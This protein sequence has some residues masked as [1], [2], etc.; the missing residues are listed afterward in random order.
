[1]S[2]SANEPL[3]TLS[4]NPTA[5]PGGFAVRVRGLVKRYAD[6][7]AANRRISA[8]ETTKVCSVI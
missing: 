6:G 1:M 7:T 4:Q 2:R 3:T 8:R 5:E